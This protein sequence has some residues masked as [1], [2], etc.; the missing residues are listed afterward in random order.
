MTQFPKS[1]IPPLPHHHTLS[2]ELCERYNDRYQTARQDDKF[3]LALKV[4][5]AARDIV[6][7]KETRWVSL[8]KNRLFGNLI[9]QARAAE[10]REYRKAAEVLEAIRVYEPSIYGRSS[11]LSIGQHSDTI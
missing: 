8:I 10:G 6:A 2:P 5:M 1:R 3:N 11:C 7:P 9:G 4:A